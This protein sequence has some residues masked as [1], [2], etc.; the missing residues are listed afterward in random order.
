MISILCYIGIRILWQ[1]L[2]VSQSLDSVWN[3]L[4]FTVLVQ[5]ILFFVPILLYMLFCKEKIN[6]TLKRFFFRKISL[7][8]VFYSVLLGIL[9]YIVVVYASSVWSIILSMFGYNYPTSTDSTDVPVWLAFLVGILSTA[10]MPGV[11]EETAHRGLLLGNFRDNGLRRA[12]MLSALMFG[13]AHLNITQFGY[14]FVVGIILATVTLTT[15]SIFP[16]IIIHG[17]SN[18]CSLYLSFATANDWI[19]SRAINFLYSI[20]DMPIVG[21]ILA[22]IILMATMFGFVYLLRKLFIENKIDKLTSDNRKVVLDIGTI[23]TLITL[24][25]IEYQF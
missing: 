13:L 23:Q 24:I 15:R 22:T 16:A 5:G 4:L 20:F 18:F 17:M 8:A 19:G 11:G 2:S 10:I 14:A 9:T 6:N 3:D 25:A 21:L 1:V 12:I 7:K